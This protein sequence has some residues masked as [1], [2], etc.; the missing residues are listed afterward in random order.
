MYLMR[1]GAPG[2]ERPIARDDDTYV[3]VSDL[4]EDFDEAFFGF[5]PQIWLQ[6]GDVMELGI[7][8]LGAQRQHVIPPRVGTSA[9]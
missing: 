1:I 4:V 9:P 8:G 2:A 5:R 7:T 6:P 3:D